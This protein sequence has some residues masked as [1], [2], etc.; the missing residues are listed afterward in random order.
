M[1]TPA[2]ARERY[3]NLRSYRRDGSTVDTPVWCAPLDDKIIVFTD[4]TSHK[5]GRIARNTRVQVAK[6]DARGKLLGP[7]QDASCRAIRDDPEYVRRAYQSLND[8]YRLW[9]KVG[10]FFSTLS[11]RVKR[12]LILEISMDGAS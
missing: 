12:R 9:M 3:I 10:T 8:K 11:G 1:S 4:G 7:W 5:V 6:C 2:L